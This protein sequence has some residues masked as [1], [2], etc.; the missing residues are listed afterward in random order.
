MKINL[1]LIIAL[2][3]CPMALLAQSGDYIIKGKMGNFNIPAKIFLNYRSSEGK[4]IKDSCALVNGKFE[5]KGYVSNPVNAAQLRLKR[6]KGDVNNGIA[7][8]LEPG[9]MEVDG[10]DSLAK[11]TIT[12]SKL[13]ADAQK[14]NAMLKPLYER[15]YK[16]N[17]TD[18]D[19]DIKAK[20]IQEE[21]IA[22]LRNFIVSNPNSLVSLSELRG[23]YGPLKYNNKRGIEEVEPIFN[24]FSATVRNSKLGKEYKATLEDWKNVGIGKLAPDFTLYNPDGKLVKLSDFKG[25]YVLVD[26]WASW[27]GPCRKEN[28]NLVNQY[29]LFKDKNFEILGVSIDVE[30]DWPKWIKAVNDDVMTWPQVAGKVQDNEARLKFHVQSIP[31]NFLINPDGYILA[32][33]LRG[34]ELNIKLAEVLTEKSKR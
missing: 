25:K 3:F 23:S 22:I 14:L 33:G 19:F 6:F 27:C 20:E 30:K 7:I 15:M 16:L 4:D 8:W 18:K 31:D 26:F 29:K 10:T 21:R 24:S 34:E 13:T 11:A 28:P 12:G 2:F 5:L 32:R 17:K 1:R 9:T